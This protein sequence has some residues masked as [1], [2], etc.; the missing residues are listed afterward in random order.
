MSYRKSK[1]SKKKSARGRSRATAWTKFVK[2]H[3]RRGLSMKQVGKLW[4]KKGKSSKSRKSGKSHKRSFR[5]HRGHG[6]SKAQKKR[7]QALYVK[8]TRAKRSGKKA[9]ARKAAK[10]ILNMKQS[11]AEH[12][13]AHTR[14]GS[15]GGLGSG[16]DAI[17]AHEAGESAKYND[18]DKK[19]GKGAWKKFRRRHKGKTA[20]TVARLWRK[21]KA[22]LARRGKSKSRGRKSSYR[23]KSKKA[24]KGKSSKAGAWRKFVSKHRRA[25]KSMKAIG[26]L[27]RKRSPR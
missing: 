13:S 23:G 6:L 22:A 10:A 2:T 7:L 3:R 27:W 14:A 18:P 25:G 21:H 8:M 12:Y 5:L 19:L 20:K 1:K 16:W 26:R 24:R 15:Y 4:R 17:A 9:A 11:V